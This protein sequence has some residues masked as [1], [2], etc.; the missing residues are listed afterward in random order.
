MCAAWL[1]GLKVGECWECWQ[2]VVRAIISYFE[3]NSACTTT[4]SH[5]Q[6]SQKEEQKKW[7]WSVGKYTYNVVL[8]LSETESNKRKHLS[9]LHFVLTSCNNI[10][11]HQQNNKAKLLIFRLNYLLKPTLSQTSKRLVNICFKTGLKRTK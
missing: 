11:Q 8:K 7:I 6:Y 9:L 2:V 5:G 3:W 10:K 1:W 4:T